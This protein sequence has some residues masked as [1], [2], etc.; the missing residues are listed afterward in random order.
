MKYDYKR[1]LKFKMKRKYIE[2]RVL[3][4]LKDSSTKDKII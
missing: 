2:K 4:L 1:I 3:K